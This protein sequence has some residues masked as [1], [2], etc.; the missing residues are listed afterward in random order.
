MGCRGARDHQ[1]HVI[2]G[3]SQIGV[4]MTSGEFVAAHLVGVAASEGEATRLGIDGIIIV[5]SL[6]QS[7]AAKAGSE[8]AADHG[9]VVQDVITAANDQPVHGMSDLANVL[10]EVGVGN[11]VKLTVARDGQS[12]SVDVTVGDTYRQAPG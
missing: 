7:P 8:G 9:S 10:E 3:T 5:Q 12:R 1:F 4:R 2:D 11:T 6:P